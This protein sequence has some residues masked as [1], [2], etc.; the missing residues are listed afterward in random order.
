MNTE[1]V[2]TR[3]LAICMFFR[4]PYQQAKAFNLLYRMANF[5][6]V[7]MCYIR[8]KPEEPLILPSPRIKSNPAIY[9]LYPSCMSLL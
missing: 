9:S 3:E 8:G 7:D 5:G 2:I 1:V 4:V 6:D